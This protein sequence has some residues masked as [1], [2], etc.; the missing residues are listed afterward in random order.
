MT[1]QV[2]ILAL[3][4][5]EDQVW[6]PAPTSKLITICNSSS[7]SSSGLCE[8]QTCIWGRDMFAGITLI[9]I[10]NKI[11]IRKDILKWTEWSKA[12]TA[13]ERQMQL[14]KTHRKDRIYKKT[15]T[16]LGMPWEVVHFNQAYIHNGVRVK[17]KGALSAENILTVACQVSRH[18]GLP[19]FTIYGIPSLATCQCFY[20]VALKAH[21]SHITKNNA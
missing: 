2:N 12:S 1:Q 3:L 9:H 16:G 20:P 11:Y 10:K 15:D 13:G 21:M 5:K 19:A 4:Q 14:T 17:N 7:S 18:Q 8:Y 6:F